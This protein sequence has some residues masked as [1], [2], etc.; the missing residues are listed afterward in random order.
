MID[1]LWSHRGFIWRNALNDLRYRYAGSALGL[2][3]NVITPLFQIMVYSTIFSG[4]MH[5]K[6]TIAAGGADSA[7]AQNN[8]N[9]TIYLCAGLLPWTAFAEGL[10]RGTNSLIANSGYLKKLRV[11]E[12][13]FIAQDVSTYLL[14]GAISMT[15]FIIFCVVVNYVPQPSWIQLIPAFLL[16]MGFA[17]GL[18]MLLASLNVFFRD[19]AQALSLILL[20]WMWMTPIVYPVQILEHQPWLLKLMPYNPAYAFIDMFHRIVLSGTW[21][22]PKHYLVPCALVAAVNVVGYLVLSRLRSDIR[23]A[24]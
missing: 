15:L 17:F 22:G 11:P 19:I 12:S 4:L 3:W 23:D 7:L 13:V 16:F 8:F 5:S 1:T 9:F 18:S 20:L 21:L 14:S 24:L 2:L 10:S 6:L